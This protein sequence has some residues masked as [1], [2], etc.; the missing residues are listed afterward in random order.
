MKKEYPK[1]RFVAPK[2][3]FDALIEEINENSSCSIPYIAN[4]AKILSCKMS[5]YGHSILDEDGDEWAD[6][7]FYN[8]EAELMIWQ[9]VASCYRLVSEQ[10]ETLGDYNELL[11]EYNEHLREMNKDT[12]VYIN[13]VDTYSRALLLACRYCA[14]Q[15]STGE[16]ESD[17]AEQL[18]NAFIEQAQNEPELTMRNS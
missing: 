18:Y 12:E 16:R 8:N 6:I 5:Q 11:S 4:G 10:N 9:Y 1:I 2:D 7:R 14:H 3:V 17:G 15:V 13:N